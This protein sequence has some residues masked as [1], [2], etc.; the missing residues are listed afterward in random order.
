MWLPSGTCRESS[1][2]S[3]RPVQRQSRSFAAGQ[4]ASARVRAAGG[5]TVEAIKAAIDVSLGPIFQHETLK[6]RARFA[7]RR[8]AADF[9]V[10]R[11]YGRLA[12]KAPYPFDADTALARIQW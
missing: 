1:M 10:R 12:A 4:A 5:S 8:G 3:S 2:S 7:L 11:R 9:E 6:R